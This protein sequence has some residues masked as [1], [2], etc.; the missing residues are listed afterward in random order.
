MIITHNM[1]AFN[2]N[3]QL[4]MVTA[5]KAKSTEKLSSGYKINRAADDAASLTI[6]EKMRRQI[7][8]LNQASDN[9]QDGVSLVQIADGGMAEVHDMLDRCIELSIKAANGTLATEDRQAIQEEINEIKKEIDQISDKTE[10]NTIKVLKGGETLYS[11]EINYQGGL[12]GWVDGGNSLNN[13]KLL[14][15][16]MVNGS[17]YRGMNLNFD[18]LNASNVSQLENNGFYT[19]CCTC[20]AHYSIKFVSGAAEPPYMSGNNNIYEVSI[21]GITTG[22]DLVQEIINTV[23]NNP[24]HHYTE[25]AIDE[26]NPA[27][28]KIYDHRPEYNPVNG[29]DP[30]SGR[31]LVGKGVAYAKIDESTP[32]GISI[33][34]GSE[35]D[36]TITIP[37]PL[38]NNTALGISGAN[39]TTEARARA[40]IDLF[41]HG[42]DY[43][44]R[45]RSRMG[46]IQ[47]RLEHTI[48][49]LDNIVENTTAAESR[50]RDTDMA[51]EMVK[52][53][54]E[55][56]LEQA[57]QAMLAQ[58]NQ[59]T[60]GILTLLQ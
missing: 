37:L 6:S 40:S 7:R 33:Q 48:K 59:S 31:G 56:I 58:A 55:N 46:A 14:D 21:D 60:Q 26:N 53:S 43:V 36:Q 20:D 28:L 3:R 38:I 41:K 51:A 9:C 2:T 11:P 25:L 54:K 15:T 12:P 16:V 50:I 44:S 39:V 27:V 8:G 47:N 19:T 17:P 22:E 52:F 1:G 5:R 49:N 13:S 30:G 4:G 35:P 42:K 10:F 34:A 45:Q 23:G 29:S 32:V 57:G 24:N 18:Q